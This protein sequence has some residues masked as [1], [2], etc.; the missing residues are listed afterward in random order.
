M[1]RVNK[2]ILCAAFLLGIGGVSEVRAN[3]F[4][5]L[6]EIDFTGT[7][8][9]TITYYL[10]QDASSVEISIK[11]YPG[12]TTAKTIVISGGAAGTLLG[13]NDVEWD[14]SLDAGGTVSSGVYVA[15]VKAFD[16]V[17]SDGWEMISYDTGPDSWY[18]SSAGVATNN[19]QLSPYF[20]MVYVTE[21]TGGTSSAEGATATPRGLYMHY[22]DGKYFGLSNALAFAEG[23]AAMAWDDFG[24]GNTPFG[25]ALG[26]DDRTY[27][28]SLGDTTG[29]L[30]V[31][32]AEFTAASIDTILSFYDMSNHQPIV[33]A[34]VGGEGTERVIYTVEQTP[35]AD[36]SS[37]GPAEV[38]RYNVGAATGL[39]SGAHEVVI[40]AATLPRPFA[41]EMDSDGFLYIA[42]QVIDTMAVDSTYYGLTKWDISGVS[43]VE[44]WHV[45]LNDAPPHSDLDDVGTESPA[46]ASMFAGIAL[47]EPRGRVYVS[48]RGTGGRPLH[49]VVGYDMA[50]GDSLSG[51]S[52]A[53]ALS[54]VGT[55][56]GDTT[57]L[58]NGGGNNIRD[59]FVDAAGNLVSVNSS[60]EA[61][62]M[63]SP[64]DG[65]NDFVTFSPWAIDVD[66]SSVIAS[67][68]T[69][70]DF[71]DYLATRNRAE[72]PIHYSV[73]Q[74][75]PN[76][77][78]AAT[79]ISYELP[80]A[81]DVQVTVYD[82]S[83]REVTT[84]V[85]T[86]QNPGTYSV[87]WQGKDQRGLD[88]ASG[89][90]FYKITARSSDRVSH[91]F[92]VVKR[93]VYLK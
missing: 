64:P 15:Y 14:G 92:N 50:T 42:Q 34:I 20:G 25:V 5:S 65:P 53:S 39:F 71:D 51:F 47:D 87:T 18:W 70:A 35:G 86:R 32:D 63:H 77:F 24:T 9:A 31:G 55:E 23:N 82:L 37:G 69:P 67:P 11:A 6:V 90:Y 26:P 78:N 49:N 61:L 91:P 56:V 74:N 83:G 60:S 29:G 21:R 19:R 62:R 43:P 16:A 58:A 36:G 68:L 17:G 7:F 41:L 79:V 75:Y 38:R 85:N 88:V 46:H 93:M 76:P 52:F 27:L 22:P 10:N 73:A 13:F 89:V 84:L 33:R 81:S 30:V 72:L 80:I 48:R 54:I 40:P 8:P 44:V 1:K 59:I 66:A 28:W 12:A 45:G 3:I 4:A 57:L 2:W